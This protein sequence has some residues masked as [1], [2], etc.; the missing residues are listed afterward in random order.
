MDLRTFLWVIFGFSGRISRAAYFLANV[1]ISLFPLFALYRLT[2][3]PDGAEVPSGWTFLFLAFA[4]VGLWSQL[5]LGVKRLH[6]FGRPGVIAV[7]LFIPFLS[8]F[9][10]LLLCFYPGN[11]GPNQYGKQTNSPR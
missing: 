11:P 8:I 3:L 1:L 2:L 10:F 5:A 7:T 6:D 9:I 4:V